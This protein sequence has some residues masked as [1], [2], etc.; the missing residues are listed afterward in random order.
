MAEM[1]Y[2]HLRENLAS[3]LDRMVDDREIGVAGRSFRVAGLSDDS[4]I[5]QP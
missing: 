3:V 1:T 2:R 4:A 5:A